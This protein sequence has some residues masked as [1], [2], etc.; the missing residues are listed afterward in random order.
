MDR[1]L[2]DIIKQAGVGAGTILAVLAPWTDQRIEGLLMSLEHADPKLETLLDIRSELR[3][4]RRF[5][6]D[7]MSKVDQAKRAAEANRS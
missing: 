7:M 5:R 3:V 6:R 1:S 4:L 2:D